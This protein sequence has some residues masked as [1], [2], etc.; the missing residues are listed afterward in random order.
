MKKL[1]KDYSLKLGATRDVVLITR[2][3][4]YSNWQYKHIFEYLEVSA[5]IDH[6]TCQLKTVY[7]DSTRIDWHYRLLRSESDSLAN[8]QG[9]E[10]AERIISAEAIE[11]AQNMIIR[12]VKGIKRILASG[13]KHPAYHDMNIEFKRI[14]KH[15]KADFTYHDLLRLAEL[16]KEDI[17]ARFIWMIR[18]SGTWIITEKG[19]DFARCIIESQLKEKNHVCFF[20]NGSDLNRVDFRDLASL[21]NALPRIEDNK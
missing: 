5:D 1:K 18:E 6:D 13:R 3:M 21:Y 7:N 14:V 20:Y 10:D 17:S 9:P 16:A 19:S 15:Y 4:G 8:W 12:A 2:D 11:D